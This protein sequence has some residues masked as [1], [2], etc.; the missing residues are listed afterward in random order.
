MTDNQHIV[1]FEPIG[2]RVEISHGTNIMEAARKGGVP[3]KADCGGSGSCGKCRVIVRDAEKISPHSLSE[4]KLL[5]DEEMDAGYHLA[6]Q[7][8]VLDDVKVDIP[9]G[10]MSSVQRLQTDSN[11]GYDN[12]SNDEADFVIQAYALKLDPATMHD[13]RSDL[14]RALDQLQELYGLEGLKTSPNVLRTLSPLLRANGWQV[15]AIV[16]E[17][18]IVAFFAPDVT[19]LGLAVDLG[20]TKIA[21]YLVDLNTGRTL[22]AD[23]RPNPQIGYGEDVISRLVYT[24]SQEHGMDTLSDSV[25][26][27]LAELAQSLSEK[28]GQKPEQ[29]CEMC[30]VGNTAMIH[31]LMKLPVRQLSV[32]PYISTTTLPQETRTADF[33]YQFAPDC[34]IYIPPMV[35]GYIGADL[36]AMA[37]ASEIGQHDR[38]VLGIDIGTNTEIVLSRQW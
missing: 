38:T 35:A 16:R 28:V 19:P 7:A 33:G 14:T 11:T 15:Q 22:A 10:S 26:K 9:H 24:S 32:A 34:Q 21:A 30:V 27:T 3:L 37:L 23:G 31:I 6:C 17:D 12:G 13:L 5:T 29:I 18:R 1:D 8:V 36:V 20:T 2:K 4:I 25:H